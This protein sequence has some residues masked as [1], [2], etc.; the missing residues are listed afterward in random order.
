MAKLLRDSDSVRQLG[1]PRETF[2]TTRLRPKRISCDTLPSM[3]L[4]TRHERATQ[5]RDW[6]RRCVSLLQ[7]LGLGIR[8]GIVESSASVLVRVQR[9]VDSVSAH[10]VFQFHHVAVEGSCERDA[11]TT[12]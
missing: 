3:I 11:F 4:K 5:L 7:R 12:T 1:A 6:L 9:S 8:L 10:C 2:T